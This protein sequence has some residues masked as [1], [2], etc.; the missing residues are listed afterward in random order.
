MRLRYGTGPIPP[1]WCPLNH[2]G[3]SDNLFLGFMDDALIKIVAIQVDVNP[4]LVRLD[5]LEVCAEEQ[6]PSTDRVAPV[7]HKIEVCGKRQIGAFQDCGHSYRDTALVELQ[8]A[9]LILERTRAFGVGAEEYTTAFPELVF[10]RRRQLNLEQPD[11]VK[12]VDRAPTCRV[13][14]VHLSDE[15]ECPFVQF[16]SVPAFARHLT[17]LPFYPTVHDEAA[18]RKQ[19][20][21]VRVY[22]PQMNVWPRPTADL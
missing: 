16:R 15:L 5:R 2:A 10:L 18:I 8:P 6:L 22:G 1:V 19:V 13:G 7:E 20:T 12:E 3:L 17:Y 14:P 9:A 21:V 11:D 4:I